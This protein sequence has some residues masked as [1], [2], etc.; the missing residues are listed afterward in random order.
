MVAPAES[1]PESDLDAAPPRGRRGRKSAGVGRSD[2][3][4]AGAEAP[5]TAG[6]KRQRPS[7]ESA[8]DVQEESLLSPDKTR[9][10]GRLTRLT[11]GLSASGMMV[12]VKDGRILGKY[13]ELK[14]PFATGYRNP[15]NTNT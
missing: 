4:G 11:H 15:K 9:I 8:G 1:Q 7:A 3:S 6:R 12:S 13:L 2:V 5:A 10:K 14:Q